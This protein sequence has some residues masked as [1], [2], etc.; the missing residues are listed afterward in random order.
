MQ[1][2]VLVG[3]MNRTV[4]DQVARIHRDAQPL[5]WLPQRSLDDGFC[6]EDEGR[7]RRRR[8]DDRVL[9]VRVIARAHGGGG[10]LDFVSIQVM[11][12]HVHRHRRSQKGQYEQREHSN[13]G[14]THSDHRR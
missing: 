4:R 2:D 8:D 13:S 14:A 7:L 10:V 1:A 6:R 12:D 9:V 11:H 5:R 3:R